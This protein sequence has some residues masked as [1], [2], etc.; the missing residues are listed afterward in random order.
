MDEL[1]LHHSL[2]EYYGA[3]EPP[4]RC[5]PGIITLIKE[6]WKV[7]QYDGRKCMW[8]GLFMPKEQIAITLG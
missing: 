6:I 5:G 1:T 3:A 7:L 8:G 4:V 2:I